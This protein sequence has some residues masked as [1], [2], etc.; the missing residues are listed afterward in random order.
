MRFLY[1]A[2]KSI[3]GPAEVSELYIMYC[4]V[5]ALISIALSLLSL[6]V[7]PRPMAHVFTPGLCS[8]KGFHGSGAPQT[9]KLNKPSQ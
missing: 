3:Q 4:M 8:F 9:T 5:Y 7:L 1:K 2:R 6:A